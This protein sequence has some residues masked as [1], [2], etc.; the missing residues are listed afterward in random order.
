MI[1][2]NYGSESVMNKHGASGLLSMFSKKKGGGG[3]LAK[4]KGG[5]E[6]RTDMPY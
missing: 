1:S 5:G 2:T 3:F 6:R 4:K